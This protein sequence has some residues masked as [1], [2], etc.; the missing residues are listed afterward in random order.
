MKEKATGD[1]LLN[2]FHRLLDDEK[3]K[4][5]LSMIF[6]GL[7]EQQILENLINFSKDETTNA[8]IRLHDQKK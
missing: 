5:I 4:D 2:F 1:P 3:E 7:N 6:K 8:K